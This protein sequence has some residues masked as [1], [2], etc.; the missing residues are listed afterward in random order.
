MAPLK[1]MAKGGWEKVSIQARRPL[2]SDDFPDADPERVST[3]SCAF[4]M[5]EMTAPVAVSITLLKRG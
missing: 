4:A 3:H 2:R 5:F 1:E